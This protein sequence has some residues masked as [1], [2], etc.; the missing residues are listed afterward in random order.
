MFLADYQKFKRQYIGTGG[1]N[2]L[3]ERRWPDEEKEFHLWFDK[4]EIKRTGN[5][6]TVII[7]DKHTYTL[8]IST[9]FPVKS[10]VD[11]TYNGKSI[12]IFLEEWYKTHVYSQNVTM[13]QIIKDLHRKLVSSD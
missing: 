2:F 7:D 5:S 10:I 13:A 3:L 12:K 9:D 6:V 8:E 1:K 4:V 11:I